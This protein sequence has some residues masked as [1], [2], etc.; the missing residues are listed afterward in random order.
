MVRAEGRRLRRVEGQLRSRR[1]MQGELDGFDL[2][3]AV[4]ISGGARLRLEHLSR[5]L[6]R[7]ALATERLEVLEDGLYRYE[8]KRPWADGLRLGRGWA[9]IGA[10][11]RRTGALWRSSALQR[12]MSRCSAVV[13]RPTSRAEVWLLLRPASRPVAADRSAPR[14]SAPPQHARA[15]L[16]PAPR[17]MNQVRNPFNRLDSPSAPLGGDPCTVVLLQS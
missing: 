17:L 9:V 5:Y 16:G 6:L 7:P 8:L 2:L 11:W 14:T 1:A 12:L 15:R 10:P 4:R 13:T 3:A